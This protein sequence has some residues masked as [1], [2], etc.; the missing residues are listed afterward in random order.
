MQDT[1]F[2]KEL[3]KYRV[4]RRED[5]CKIRWKKIKES[6]I[7]TSNNSNTTNTTTKKNKKTKLTNNN[8]TNQQNNGLDTAFWKEMEGYATTAGFST[9]QT[10][11]FLIQLQQVYVY[12]G[13]YEYI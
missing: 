6:P 10:K 4:V 1:I 11:L 8:K 7:V 5:S 12:M 9:E 2:K 3:N 13:I